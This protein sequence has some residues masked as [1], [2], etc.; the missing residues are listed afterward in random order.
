[1]I[2]PNCGKKALEPILR[3]SPYMIIKES[4][5]EHEMN[6]GELFIQSYVNKNGYDESTSSFYLRKEL[7]NVGVNWQTLSFA[8]FWS[9]KPPKAG[10]TK[11]SRE[12]FQK[13]VDWTIQQTI[14]ACKDKKVIMM[15]GAGLVRTFTGYGISSVY[16]LTVTSDLLPTVP[17]IVPAPNPDNIMKVPIGEMRNALQTFAY[18]IK[19][20]ESYRK[21]V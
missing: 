15:M 2:C 21:V 12:E 14:E 4:A 13:C 18:E 6:V 1:M 9:H 20:Y 7:G 11:E 16:G 17:I 3:S 8:S 10:R 5:T 19:A